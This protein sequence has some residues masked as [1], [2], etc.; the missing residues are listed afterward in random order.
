M[1]DTVE[2]FEEAMKRCKAKAAAG[3]VP[4]IEIMHR[5]YSERFYVS[6]VYAEHGKIVIETGHRT[7]DH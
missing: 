5:R 6:G 4:D 3:A 1:I 7:H 2:E